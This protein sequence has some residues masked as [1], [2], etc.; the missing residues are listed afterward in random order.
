MSEAATA[1]VEGE[2]RRDRVG[3]LAL[4][5]ANLISLTGN[6][7]TFFALPWFV[8][9]TTGSTTQTALVA[10]VQMSAALAA[11]IWGGVIVDRFGPKELS[12]VSDV[13]SGL[14]IVAIPIL[15]DT[16]GLRLWQILVLA[17]VGILLD[18]P[19]GNARYGIITDLIDRTGWQP[20]RVYSA[21]S[22]AD[23]LARIAG[24]VLAGGLIAWV[25]AVNALWVDA[26]TFMISAALIAAFVPRTSRPELPASSFFGDV[27][28]G[29][30]YLRARPLLIRFFALIV[31]INLTAV[32]LAAVVVPKIAQDHYD[33]SRA[34]GVMLAADGLGVILGGIIFGMIGRR[35][36][37]YRSMLIALTMLFLSL[38]LLSMLL[39]VPVSVLALGLTGI[40]FGVMVPNNQVVY[41]RLTDVSFRGRLLGLRDA[42]V[43]TSAPTMVLIV[44]LLLDIAPIAP[45]VM[46]LG[47]INLAVLIWFV[48]EPLFWELN[49]PE[50][51]PPAR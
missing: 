51:P 21:F 29:W 42:V 5:A 3:I 39:P 8:L 18:S 17:F 45:V 16:V 37:A 6:Q 35:L 1:A 48:R 24:P 23:G 12:V 7:I 11:S 34:G 32:P 15:M 30:D 25:G 44:G 47:V 2:S 22:S 50:A 28:A 13:I 31:S 38:V 49:Q 20:E 9:E 41:R 4:L 27:R 46:L 40:G 43:G 19:G 14:S 36:T 26:T 33:S 10:A